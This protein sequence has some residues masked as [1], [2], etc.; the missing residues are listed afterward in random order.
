MLLPGRPDTRKHVAGAATAAGRDSCGEAVERAI[1]NLGEEPGLVLFFPTGHIDADAAAVEAWEAARGACVAGMTGTCAIGGDGL[2]E[3]GCSAIAFSSTLPAGVGAV[4]GGD[5]RAA[6]R[7]AVVTA[8]AGTEAAPYRVV[9]LFVDSESGDQAEI[10]A[11]AYA[12]AGGRIA[13]AGGAAGGDPRARFAADRA[14][15]GGV[16]A[17]ALG[18]AAPIGVGIAHGCVPRG[19]PSIVTRSDGPNVIQLDGRPAADVYLERLGVDGEVVGPEEFDMLA[20]IHP[21]AEPELSGAIRPRYVRARGPDGAL[22]CATSIERNAAVEICDQSPET[23]IESARVAVENAFGQLKAR[24]DAAVVFDCAARSAW[25]GGALA[26]RELEALVGA[27]GSPAP[28]LAGVFTRGEIGR[29]RGAKGDR[30]H[31]VVVAA[32]SAPD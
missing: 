29:A 2:I 25:F 7:E 12:V 17:V 9:L 11:G 19:A 4:E 27:F 32:F 20:M 3:T 21:L 6:A 26:Q 31:S 14:F 24:C 10:V 30:N 1:A 5:P 28:A 18:S 15:S 22:V 8:L 23:V 13:L 16:V